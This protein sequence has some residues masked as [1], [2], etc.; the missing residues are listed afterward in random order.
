MGGAASGGQRHPIPPGA[1]F[2]AL[3]F[4]EFHASFACSLISG[5]RAQGPIPAAADSIRPRLIALGKDELIRRCGKGGLFEAP[6]APDP[7]RV[8]INELVDVVAPYTQLDARNRIKFDWPAI[9]LAVVGAARR[10]NK[11][12]AS[13]AQAGAEQA[14][15]DGSDSEGTGDDAGDGDSGGDGSGGGGGDGV[16]NEAADARQTAA[17]DRRRTRTVNELFDRVLDQ[18]EQITKR[19]DELERRV[20]PQASVAA[21]AS[22]WAPLPPQAPAAA[23]GGRTNRPGPNDQLRMPPIEVSLYPSLQ[24]SISR[25]KIYNVSLSAYHTTIKAIGM[26]QELRRRS[27]AADGGG[28]LRGSLGQLEVM[29]DELFRLQGVLYM[30]LTYDPAI[31]DVAASGTNQWVEDN[32]HLIKRAEQVV[33]VT[34]PKAF[35]PTGS[36][37]RASA[38]SS[39]T[40]SGRRSRRRPAARRTS[41]SCAKHRR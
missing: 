16:T 21:Q 12:K 34:T 17:R 41:S 4:G 27:E 23:G 32:R 13:A 39:T 9:K 18:Q 3:L 7:E 25:D 31:A 37:C 5:T 30:A 28:L 10:P 14:N 22:T 15:D 24:T 1:R 11:R 36:A 8:Q 26:V 19:F 38:T 6:G 35:G 29:F 40:S 2:P 33:K 20:A